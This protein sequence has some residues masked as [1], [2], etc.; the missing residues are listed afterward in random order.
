MKKLLAV[1]LFLLSI[2]ILQAQ[3]PNPANENQVPAIEQNSAST[4]RAIA[5]E[6]FRGDSQVQSQIVISLED[7]HLDGVTV[8]VTDNTIEIS[9]K[10]PDKDA[11]HLAHDIACAYADG[12]KVEDH[13]THE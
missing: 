4:G 2:S 5:A 13:T 6:E 9:G 12:R 8:K 1:A 7:H 10:L 3:T 11:Q